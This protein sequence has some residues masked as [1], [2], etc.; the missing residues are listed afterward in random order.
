MADSWFVYEVLQRQTQAIEAAFALLFVTNTSVES[1]KLR[2]QQLY[3]TCS[4][5]LV[6]NF[7]TTKCK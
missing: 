2:L 7:F 6:C 4:S 3:T 1:I 5:I